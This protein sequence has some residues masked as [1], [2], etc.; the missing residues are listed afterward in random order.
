M[1]L[2]VKNL[3]IGY[4]SGS[5]ETVLLKNT[6][7]Q[8]RKGAV[9]SIF[10]ANGVG[11]STLIH[12]LCGIIP[13]LKGEVK[14]GNSQITKIPKKELSKLISIVL[15]ERPFIEYLTVYDFVAFGR[16]PH[17][18]FTGYLNENDHK[19]ISESMAMTEIAHKS[20]QRIDSL[21]DGEFQKALIAR[22]LTQQTP[23]I[24]M[25]EPA[26]YLDFANQ[27]QLMTLLQKLATES[28]KT[29]LLSLHHLNLAIDYSNYIF[30]FKNDQTLKM[31]T[32]EDLILNNDFENVYQNNDLLFDNLNGVFKQSIE[33]KITLEVI[34]PEL[35]KKWIIHAL[36]KNGFSNILFTIRYE[37]K[38]YQLIQH[39]EI[40]AE[41]DS[42]DGL[43]KQ[44]SKMSGKR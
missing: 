44:I 30:I 3:S 42:I 37:H 36:V 15:T 19:I 5:S 43:L 7:F 18:D 27:I 8:L 11:K 4:R 22:A 38:N 24:I 20:T 1:I 26:S 6:N 34:A 16:T 28:G 40:I 12:T 9:Y 29:I 13:S 39:N 25:D 31:G 10:G 35:Q 14:I 33:E 23:I 21:S 41:V 32:P 2:E 17:T